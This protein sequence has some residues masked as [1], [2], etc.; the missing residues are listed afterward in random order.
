MGPTACRSGS[1]P[2]PAGVVR[3]EDR[4]EEVARLVRRHHHRV[5]SDSS[6]FSSNSVSP[7]STSF[8]PVSPFDVLA[9]PQPGH[10]PAQRVEVVAAERRAG[11]RDV[12][13][14]GAAD[15]VVECLVGEAQPHLLVVD[16]ED[17]A[18]VGLVRVRDVEVE[19]EPARPQERGSSDSTKFVVPTT[20]TSSSLWNPSISVRSWLTIECSTPLPV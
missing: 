5:L 12:V 20:K 6:T 19:L 10:A 17:L 14:A 2:S 8:G 3:A 7:R 18:A 16:L 13:V 4:H 15:G 11:R 9:H 1:S